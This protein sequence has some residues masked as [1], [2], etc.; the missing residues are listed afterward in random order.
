MGD[1]QGSDAQTLLERPQFI[2]HTLP[3]LG[4]QIGQRL[5]K[6]QHGRLNHHG[7]SQRHA[8]LLAAGELIGE[9][10]FHSLELHQLHHVVGAL[11]D[12]ILRQLG[13]PQAVGNIFPDIQVGEKGVGLEHH[14][15]APLVGGDFGNVSFADKHIA[16][17]GILKAGDHP[18]GGGFAAAGGAQ[19]RHHLTVLDFQ[20]DVVN[21]H[22]ILAGIRLLEDFRYVLQDHAGAFLAEV[23][24]IIFMAHFD[25]SVFD[26]ACGTLER[27]ASRKL[28]TALNRPM[29]TS[30]MPT[31]MVTKAAA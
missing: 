8:L 15:N 2:P 12:L 13:Y 27:G 4:V 31:I 3:E 29:N 19:Q 17:G 1:I 30:R 10:L 16:A 9:P 23:Q 25:S 21:S 26:L 14:G 20:I 18:Q 22:E 11:D 5:V 28:M 7:A 24:L 6:Q